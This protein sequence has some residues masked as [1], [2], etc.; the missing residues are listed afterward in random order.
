MRSRPDV[1]TS[2]SLSLKGGHLKS[3]LRCCLA[4]YITSPALVGSVY[5]VMGQLA[6][7]NK[8]R[9]KRIHSILLLRWMSDC[10]TCNFRRAQ[11]RVTKTG[12][13]RRGQVVKNLLSDLAS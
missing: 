9:E 13:E 4:H 3:R 8:K 12:D 6:S 7:D 2:L 1:G 11:P 10:D 5:K